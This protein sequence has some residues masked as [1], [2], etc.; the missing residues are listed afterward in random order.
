MILEGEKE[1]TKDKKKGEE[2]NE[3][4]SYPQQGIVYGKLFLIEMYNKKYFL[5]LVRIVY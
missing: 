4:Q 5:H 1:R 3:D 2:D